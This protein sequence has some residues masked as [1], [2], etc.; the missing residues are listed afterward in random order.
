MS[1][2]ATFFCFYPQFTLLHIITDSF[3]LT[4]YLHLH[5]IYLDEKLLHNRLIGDTLLWCN[6]GISNADWHFFDLF[7]E[8]KT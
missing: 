2:L 5:I 6:H 7:F 3:T 1:Q 8:Q 4:F